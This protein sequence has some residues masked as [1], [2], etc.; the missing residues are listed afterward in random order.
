MNSHELAL[1][2]AGAIGCIVA[3]IHGVLTQRIL[4]KPILELPHS[5]LGEPLKRL[6]ASLLQFTTFNWFIMGAAL[7]VVTFIGQ[8]ET[9]AVVAILAASSFAFGA[10]VNLWSLRRLHPGWLLYAIAVGAIAYG[11]SAGP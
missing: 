1:L 6:G 4:V 5:N 11:L 8:P 10:A 9:R 2:S 7:C 3:A